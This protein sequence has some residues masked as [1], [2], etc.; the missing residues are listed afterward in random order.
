MIE[1]VA[2]LTVASVQLPEL[3]EDEEFRK[4]ESVSL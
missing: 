3:L 1:S 2:S 4:V